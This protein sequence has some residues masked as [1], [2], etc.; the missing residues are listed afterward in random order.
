MMTETL[1]MIAS[2]KLKETENSKEI[3]KQR[4]KTTLMATGCWKENMTEIGY[5]ID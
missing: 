4:P 1:K 5:L 3:L 2:L